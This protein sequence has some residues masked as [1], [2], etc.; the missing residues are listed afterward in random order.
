[1]LTPNA[2][3][4]DWYPEVAALKFETSTL[5]LGLIDPEFTDDEQ[6]LPLTSMSKS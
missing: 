2:T 4:W 6:M 5:A 1:M 3:E